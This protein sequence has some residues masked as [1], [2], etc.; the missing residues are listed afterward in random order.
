MTTQTSTKKPKPQPETPEQ[1]RERIERNNKLFKEA[2]P[3]VKRK[4][5]AADVIAQIKARKF[6]PTR[7]TWLQLRSETG[8]NIEHI[9]NY[10]NSNKTIKKSDKIRDLFIENKIAKCDCCALGGL[11]MSCSLFTGN[12]TVGKFDNEVNSLGIPDIL[13]DEDQ[14]R[15]SNNLNT[16]F[17]P[18]QLQLI[19]LAFESGN[20][21]VRPSEVADKNLAERAVKFN[22]GV[23]STSTRLKA[24]MTNIIDN[25]G[26]FVP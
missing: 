2:A 9:V 7:G 26:T 17:S 11:F 24:I 22:A 10:G 1:M 6:K 12:T 25:D 19:E 15:M 20:G 4:M 23:S 21:G 5:I 18:E 3:E 16:I 13:A 14:K 8:A